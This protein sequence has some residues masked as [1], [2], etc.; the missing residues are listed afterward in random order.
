MKQWT[1]TSLPGVVAA[2]SLSTSWQLSEGGHCRPPV[3]YRRRDV[4]MQGCSAEELENLSTLGHCLGT[5]TR[6]QRTEH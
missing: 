4:A 1:V 2:S 3:C 5:M 6:H